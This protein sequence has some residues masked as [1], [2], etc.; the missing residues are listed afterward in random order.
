MLRR[1]DLDAYPLV[2]GLGDMSREAP[3]RVTLMLAD[4][5]EQLETVAKVH[6]GQGRPMTEEAICQK[7]ATTGGAPE[8][9]EVILMGPGDEKFRLSGL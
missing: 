4:G 6:G 2:P 5:R 7:Y 8:V 9:A 1:V 3:D